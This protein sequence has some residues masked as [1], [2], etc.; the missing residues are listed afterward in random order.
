MNS[1]EIFRDRLMQ[2][3][4]TLVELLL[5]VSLTVIISAFIFP[6]GIGF[7]EAQ[8]V[9]ETREGIVNTLRRA[10]YFAITG[11]RESAFGVKIVPGEYI[12][13]EGESYESRIASNDE[14]Y[15]TPKVVQYDGFD[16]VVF[17]LWSGQPST[18]GIFT[19]TLGN[20]H[21]DIHIAT[22]GNIE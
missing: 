1:R 9:N 8:V 6:F 20:R 5:A 7:Y 16:E 4:F 19:V 14:R 17:N 18:S 22:S 15:S 2:R 21:K 10:Q 11:K 3:G 12:L 13:F